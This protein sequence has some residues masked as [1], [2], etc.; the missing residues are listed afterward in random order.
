[1][2]GAPSAYNVILGRSF[3]STFMVVVSSYHQKIKFSIGHLV[4]RVQGDQKIAQDCY[5]KMIKYDQNRARTKG[6]VVDASS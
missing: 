4:G 2:V 6:K 5:V 1:M 3:F